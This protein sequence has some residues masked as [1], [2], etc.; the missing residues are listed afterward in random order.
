MTRIYFLQNGKLREKDTRK[1]G[2]KSPT[3]TVVDETNKQANRQ[4]GMR[5][6]A[7]GQAGGQV[8]GESERN[9]GNINGIVAQSTLIYGVA[10]RLHKA[11]C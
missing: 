9:V 1:N 4:A 11:P 10:E 8:G 5:R 7:G 2:P 3:E 6:E